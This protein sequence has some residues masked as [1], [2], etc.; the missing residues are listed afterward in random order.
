MGRECAFPSDCEPTMVVLQYPL[1]V[2]SGRAKRVAFA[3]FR[4][5]HWLGLDRPETGSARPKNW[6]VSYRANRLGRRPYRTYGI[7]SRR[8]TSGELL[9]QRY[10]QYRL[11]RE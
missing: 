2:D 6:S 5:R 11:P 8:M 3:V 7:T 1:N 10:K 9:K 4:W